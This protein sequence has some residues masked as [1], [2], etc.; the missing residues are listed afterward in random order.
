MENILIIIMGVLTFMSFIGSVKASGKLKNFSISIFILLLLTSIVI[1]IIINNNHEKQK[2]ED[3]GKIE[4]LTKKN[5]EL[6]DF[7]NATSTKDYYEN[8]KQT[9]MLDKIIE[10]LEQKETKKD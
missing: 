6:I 2:K 1:G 4:N 10:K 3:N 7:N 5:K 8:Q 9:K